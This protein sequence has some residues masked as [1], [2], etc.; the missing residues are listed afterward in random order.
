MMICEAGI[1]NDMA[2]RIMHSIL[3]DIGDRND[4]SWSERLSTTQGT[5]D[6]TSLEAAAEG[7]SDIIKYG[8]IACIEELKHYTR[9][10]RREV[11]SKPNK[12]TYMGHSIA[13]KAYLNNDFETAIDICIEAFSDYQN[14]NAA[15]GGV[16]WEK[17]AKTIKSIIVLDKQFKELHTKRKD[18]SFEW[19]GKSD[20]YAVDAK[21]DT[22]KDIVI[23]LNVF[24]GLAHNTDSIMPKL[25][26]EE[27]MEYNKKNNYFYGSDDSYKFDK[28][29]DLVKRMMDAKELKDSTHTYREVEPALQESGD[30]SRWRDW[31]GKIKSK[32]N[33]YIDENTQNINLINVKI[34]KKIKDRINKLRVWLS[35][36]GEAEF[37]GKGI[38]S[39]QELLSTASHAMAYITYA[40]SSL[41]REFKIYGTPNGRQA[42]LT[43]QY[44]YDYY[45]K[46]IEKLDFE[47]VQLQA[48]Q[49]R[50]TYYYTNEGLKEHP[51]RLDNA[52]K[53]L[54]NF[55][56]KAES[57][58]ETYEQ[59]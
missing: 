50:F 43:K 58:I 53:D 35:E 33:Y 40:M 19:K 55:Y 30:I 42:D 12:D 34:H 3:P 49:H 25:I 36:I 26:E 32:P 2:K 24:D 38:L 10:N 29:T 15:Y 4:P 13:Q 21:I 20:P 17:I 45:D 59:F 7:R 52:L 18:E 39:N 6:Y 28:E 16:A 41:N 8:T 31:T 46:I 14:W 22:L 23:Q 9:L 47:V 54:L 51:E 11:A 56:N 48:I 57:L 5:V 27:G 1:R 44:Q 37:A